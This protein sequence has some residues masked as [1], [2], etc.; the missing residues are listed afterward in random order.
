MVSAPTLARQTSKRNCASEPRR[1]R[2]MDY[3]QRKK[4]RLAGY[5]YSSC[6][7]YFVTVCIAH[8]HG[9]LW[10]D[11]ETVGAD[12]IRPVRMP[13]LS[14]CGKLVDAAIHEIPSH[15]ANVTVIHYCIMP[16]HVHLLLS[17]SSDTPNHQPQGGRMV[18]APTLSTVVGQMKRSVSKRIGHPVWQK[19][20]YDKIIRNEKS[21]LAAWQYIDENPANW[22]EDKLFDPG[23]SEKP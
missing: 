2:S 4:I 16:D 3:R 5:D 14:D 23:L 12:I 1:E 17:I 9:L 18:S 7:T 6:G 19:S 22:Q 11:P 20:F 13:T 15:Y 8:R 21:F 10:E